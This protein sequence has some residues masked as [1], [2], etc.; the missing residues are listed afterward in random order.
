MATPLRAIPRLEQK[1][2]A[3]LT[4][5]AHGISMRCERRKGR[6]Y[7]SIDSTRND[8]PA[9]LLADRA[10]KLK[11]LVAIVIGTRSD[12][13]REFDCFNDEIRTHVLELVEQMSDEVDMLAKL[14][15][16]HV[17]EVVDQLRDEHAG[18]QQ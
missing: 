13:R 6:V 9:D 2:R 11:S 5:D 8:F 16:M 10:A 18:A 4:V 15:V 14:N 12:E 1:H 17:C 3:P 7:T